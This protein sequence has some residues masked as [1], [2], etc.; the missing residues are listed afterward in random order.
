MACGRPATIADA[1]VQ[2]GF[3]P[4]PADMLAAVGFALFRG[5]LRDWLAE[6]DGPPLADRIR[7]SLPR[8]RFVLDEVSRTP[9]ARRPRK[10]SAPVVGTP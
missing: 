4:G 2:R 7:A 9:G 6:Q 10:R 1:L 8:V 5:V 3:G